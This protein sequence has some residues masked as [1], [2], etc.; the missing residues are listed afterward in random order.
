MVD[1]IRPCVSRGKSARHSDV[2][3][4]VMSA[5]DSEVKSAIPI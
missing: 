4:A 3:S 2:M 1:I 5:S